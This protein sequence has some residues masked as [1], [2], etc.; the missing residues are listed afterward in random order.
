MPSMARRLTD[1]EWRQHVVAALQSDEASQR[2]IAAGIIKTSGLHFTG[3]CT[4]P[5]WRD[6]RF[7]RIWQLPIMMGVS[8]FGFLVFAFGYLLRQ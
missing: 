7:Y 8:V 1:A 4:V 2:T 5:L 6:P 3:K